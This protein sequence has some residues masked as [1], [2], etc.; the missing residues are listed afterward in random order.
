VHPRLKS[1]FDF[2]DNRSVHP[3][4]RACN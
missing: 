3:K 4:A 1:P 2:F